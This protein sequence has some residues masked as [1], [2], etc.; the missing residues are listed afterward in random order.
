MFHRITKGKPLED[1]LRSH[2]GCK[3]FDF[4]MDRVEITL[5]RRPY[6]EHRYACEYALI[7]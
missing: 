6:E 4:R 7:N 2:T 3:V 5:S 1:Q